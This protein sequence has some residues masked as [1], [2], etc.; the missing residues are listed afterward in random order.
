M[1]GVF[2]YAGLMFVHE[3]GSLQNG[4]EDLPRE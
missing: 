2:A 1:D 4:S 3:V